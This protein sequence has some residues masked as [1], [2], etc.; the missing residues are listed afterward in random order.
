VQHYSIGSSVVRGRVVNDKG[1]PVDGAALLI[2]KS[3]IFTDTDGRFF[4]REPKPHTHRLQVL[5]DKF[6]N[7]GT[8][9]VESAPSSVKATRDAQQPEIL[10]VVK[11]RTS[12]AG[13]E[14]GPG[15]T[16]CR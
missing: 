9:E 3:A 14:P 8:Y 11:Q 7:G 4:F 16:K 2:D 10:I 13:E 1:Q 6:L 12:A 5:T 15:A